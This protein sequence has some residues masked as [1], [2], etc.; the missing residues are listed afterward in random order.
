[1]G[2]STQKASFQEET[3]HNSL[4]Q[5]VSFS[6]AALLYP[7]FLKDMAAGTPRECSTHHLPA[8]QPCQLPV[9]APTSPTAAGSQKSLPTTPS[10]RWPLPS[11]QASCISH[12][13]EEDLV[14][15]VR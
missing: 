4:T 12:A 7:C 9:I 15:E 6:Q 10:W 8:M 1:M 13:E 2:Q 3:E 14:A 11:T 5:L